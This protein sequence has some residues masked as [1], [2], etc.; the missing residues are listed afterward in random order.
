VHCRPRRLWQTTIPIA[1]LM[2]S[3]NATV[4]AHLNVT[5]TVGKTH[6]HPTMRVVG[7]ED[8]AVKLWALRVS[9]FFF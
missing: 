7:P 3:A 8:A 6:G 1:P 2:M 5:D 9:H 4:L